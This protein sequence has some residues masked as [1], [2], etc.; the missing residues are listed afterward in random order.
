MKVSGPEG[1]VGTFLSMK[2]SGRSHANSCIQR[3][4]MFYQQ[5][6]E[7]SKEN[8]NEQILQIQIDDTRDL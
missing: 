6:T 8:K 5:G 4:N 3:T 1:K 2:N 7:V